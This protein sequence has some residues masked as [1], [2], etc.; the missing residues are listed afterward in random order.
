MAYINTNS[1]YSHYQAPRS[2]AF[3]GALGPKPK[4][5]SVATP[6]AGAPSGP[7]QGFTPTPANLP[8]D[9]VYQ[10]TLSGLQG[11][12]G[13]TLAGLTQNRGAY[14]RNAGFIEDPNTHTITYDP[15]NPYSQ[16]ALLRQNYHQAQAGNSNSYADRGLGYAGSLSNAQNAT[17]D[18]YNRSENGLENAVINFL[19][20]NTIQQ[21]AAQNAYTTGAGQ[22][23]GQSIQNAPNNPLYNPMVGSGGGQISSDANGNMAITAGAGG[24]ALVPQQ[25]N[26]IV[27]LASGWSIE[28]GP[29]GKPIKFIPPGG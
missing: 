25:A 17:T 23:L 11:T 15:N 1:F 3:G 9:P 19:A 24:T 28:Y 8:P 7:P 22:A 12:L 16:A 14:L 5:P 2:S 21:G 10:Q 20:N 29:D 13:N 27:K 6:P 4:A 18:N 26:S